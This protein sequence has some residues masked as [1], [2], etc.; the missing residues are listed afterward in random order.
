[1]KLAAVRIDDDAAMEL[2]A[3]DLGE[4]LAR[5]GWRSA[6]ESAD[7]PRPETPAYANREHR[8]REIDNSARLSVPRFRRDLHRTASVLD[9]VR[10]P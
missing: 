7:G 9:T 6:A 5:L 2:G 4:F 10:R 8:A 1:V 3:A